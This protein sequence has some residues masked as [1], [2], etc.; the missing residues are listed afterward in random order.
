MFKVPNWLVRL[1]KSYTV[2]TAA[3]KCATL[4]ILVCLTNVMHNNV[5]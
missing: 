3:H 4:Y 1:R 5:Q 2:L